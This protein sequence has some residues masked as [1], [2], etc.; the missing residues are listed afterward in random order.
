MR[1][2]LLV[3][4]ALVFAQIYVVYSTN[5][6][7]AVN[8]NGNTVGCESGADT[9]YLT[10]AYYPSQVDPPI[11]SIN[12]NPST[13]KVDV[14][15]TAKYLPEDC[16]YV[17]RF[18]PFNYTT[19]DVNLPGTCEN[20]VASTFNGLAF[21][22]WWNHTSNA[23]RNAAIGTNRTPAYGPA[24]GWV[25]TILDCATIRWTRSFSLSELANC[26][27]PKGV[28]EVKVT[29]TGAGGAIIYEGKLA[30][31]LVLPLYTNFNQGSKYGYLVQIWYYGFK[32]TFYTS[33]TATVLVS[34]GGNY[35][36][37]MVR[38][39]F[40]VPSGADQGKMYL[41]LDTTYF[42][43]SYGFLKN[44]LLTST[45]GATLSLSGVPSTSI[46]PS[47]A[48]QTF[49]WVSNNVQSVYDGTYTFSWDSYDCTSPSNISTCTKSNTF[50]TTF[51]ILLRSFSDQEGKV[52]LG[53]SIT[54]YK[55]T[56]FSVPKSSTF[57]EGTPIC[58]KDTLAVA[59]EDENLYG[60][61]I[62]NAYL[63]APN[64]QTKTLVYDGIT[65]FGCLN[66]SSSARLVING[67]TTTASIGSSIYGY[68]NPT[69]YQMARSI[70]AGLCI[71]AQSKFMHSNGT[72]RTDI[73]KQYVQIEVLITKLSSFAGQPTQMR[74]MSLYG[75]N[76]NKMYKIKDGIVL[77]PSETD[78]TSSPTPSITLAPRDED[79]DTEDGAGGA[80][81]A[82]DVGDNSAGGNFQVPTNSTSSSE[83]VQIV[84]DNTNAPTF[85][86]AFQTFTVVAN[87][88]H[89]N[90]SG[91]CHD[92]S[93][94]IFRGFESNWMI[95][96]C[97]TSFW[98]GVLTILFMNGCGCSE[99]WFGATVKRK[100]KD[101]T[102]PKS[103]YYTRT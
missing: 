76:D 30:I 102:A 13:K 19:H 100:K 68:Y 85:T 46:Q 90:N 41:Q 24:G 23:R 51:G 35:L 81:G 61:S 87:S 10:E 38:S 54:I 2:V 72:L 9:T 69:V 88:G 42:A 8:W 18:S 78:A 60:I 6:R 28:T 47:P 29:D 80:G 63:C 92:G 17:V 94:R 33:S 40:V 7:D 57:D 39:I 5:A 98:L 32:M 65:N 99:H 66:A 55:D 48:R 31:S 58:F 93:D 52:S 14:V 86:S 79:E 12:Y 3:V 1:N 22:K 83:E 49:V 84:P 64:D 43:D 15:A 59:N 71:N 27:D 73:F 56:G 91:N 44:N 16:A 95:V 62:W 26:K 20:R 50:T 21:D 45:T 34:S 75:V 67:S 53:T 77:P 11:V 36:D 70:D 4:G 101:D 74:L 82:G 96:F 37:V 25:Q 103:F 89:G 97:I